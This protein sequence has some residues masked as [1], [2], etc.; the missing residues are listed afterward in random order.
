MKISY[1]LLKEFVKI[2]LTPEK[3]AETVTEHSVE[4]ELLNGQTGDFSGIFAAKVLEIKKHPNADRLRIV[5]LDIGGKVVEPVVCGA[6]NFKEED[7][8]ALALPGAKISRNI[9]SEEHEAFILQ[10]ANI[11][12]QESQ[13]MICAAF[14]LGLSE[15]IG[16]GILL[17][18]KNTRP[19]RSLSEIFSAKNPVFEAALPANRP[20]LHSHWG[21]A[22]E[23]NAIL[24]AKLKQPN[25]NTGKFKT[26]KN[27]KVKVDSKFCRKY[28]GVRLKNVKVGVSPKFIQDELSSVGLRPI[29]NVVDITN[30]VMVKLGQPTH[31]YDAAKVKGNIAVRQAKPGEKFIAINHKEYLLNPEMYVVADG[32]KAIALGGL[33]GGLD[34]EITQTTRDIILE[35]A[36]FDAVITRRTS[37]KTKLKTDGS[38]IWEKGIHPRLADFGLAL[39]VDLLQK[40][41]GAE[42]VE[43]IKFQTP[44]KTSVHVEF[45]PEQINNLLGADFK[46][47]EIKTL[48]T[49]YEIKVSGKTKMKAVIPWWRSDL[50]IPADLAEELIKLKGYNS[51][52]LQ[53]PLITPRQA[54][55][56]TGSG[57]SLFIKNSKGFWARLGY[58][59]AQNY[60]FVSEKDL[61]NFGVSPKDHLEIA[62]P[63]SEDQRYLKR[64]PIIPLL[65]NL[66][67]N[68]NNFSSLKLFEIAK[69]YFGFENEPHLLLAVMLNKHQPPEKLLMQAKNAILE[70]GKFL[71]HNHITFSKANEAALEIKH[72]GESLGYVGLI[73]GKIL[74]NFNVD[75][76]AAFVKLELGKMLAL[77]KDFKFREI[78]KF[79]AVLRDISIIITQQT[80]WQQIENLIYPVSKLITKI[81]LFEAPFLAQDK[82]TQE[83]QKNLQNKS[84]KNYG[85]RLTLEA[86][87][88]TLTDPEVTGILGQIVLKLKGELK[89]EIR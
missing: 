24:G 14:E 4:M 44:E 47:A 8:V 27:W 80:S 65:K 89:A 41:A 72:Q 26:A 11:R 30:Y 58:S 12:G 52:K 7:V 6:D 5:K 45:F 84:L 3:L 56:K 57:V 37:Q 75:Y 85:I 48:L 20:D 36:N 23:I 67:T 49:R 19:G 73:A 35:V 55:E 46:I 81:E 70:Y 39:S 86:F 13:G 53:T 83:Y 43:M 88:H 74:K 2:N 66:Q 38:L 40:Y 15:E 63:L 25:Q 69:Q 31:T 51:V 77:Q 68:Q 16:R 34:T 1:N 17:L 62:N 60:N 76:P 87:N 21:L 71:G 59:E 82:S 50:S 64:Y 10:K 18:D 22:R 79:P 61:V 32:E 42:I 54:E 33:I 29:N 28:F 78:N 9:H